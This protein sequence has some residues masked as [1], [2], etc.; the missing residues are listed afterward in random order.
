VAYDEFGMRTAFLF[1][2]GSAL[3]LAQRPDLAVIQK[4][5]G[6]VGFY[7][8]DG[9]LISEV[10][11]DKHP[12][13]AVLSPDGKLLYVTNNGIL[14]MTESGEGGNTISIVDVESRKNIGSIDLGRYHRPH[15]IDLDPKTGRLVVTIENPSG[16][17]HVD[18]SQR[19]VLRMY[20][21]KG[22]APH[23]VLLS[24]DGKRAYVSNTGT[25]TLSIVDLETAA[26]KVIPSAP[27][28]QGTAFSPDRK[29]IY[30]TN[31]DGNSISIFDVAK[32][33]RTGMINTGKGPC[34]IVATADGKTL[35]Y[36][37]QNSEAV[38]FADIASGKEVQQVPLGGK[39]VSLTVSRDGRLAYSS[40]QEQDK[41]S[42]LSIAERKV[43]RVIN[44]PK[45][46]GPDPVIALR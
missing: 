24:P 2:L 37:L 32:R 45:G 43:I 20:D 7:T 12:H 44:T 31:L 33:E 35:V 30:M 23:M 25:G 42:V 40:A 9:H 38:G 5:S 36:A 17:L 14:W 18:P 46:S 19:K 29:T 10:K 13:E 16:L 8:N 4:I 11:V 3:V 1:F 22:E 15:G 27:R 39:L 41:I 34:R 26:V 21:V 6:T 28:P